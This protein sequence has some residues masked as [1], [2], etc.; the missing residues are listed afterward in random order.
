MQPLKTIIS[1]LAAIGLVM[2][3][4]ACIHREPAPFSL[5]PGLFDQEQPHTLGLV[6]PEGAETYTIYQ[7]NEEDNAYNHGV[8]LIA[9]KGRLYAQ[10]QSSHRDEDAPDTQVLYSSSSNLKDWSKPETLAPARPGAV[11]TNGGWW[12]DS[13]TLVAYITTWPDRADAP[14]GGYTQYIT[15]RDGV[16]WSKPK[17]MLNEKGLPVD[18]V[19]EQDPHALPDGRIISAFHE[20]PGL[21]VSPYY[22]DDPLAVS[23][24][25]KGAMPNLPHEGAVSRELEPSWFCRDDGA[26]VMVFRDQASSYK[27]LASVSRDRGESWTSP[28]LVDFPD[29]RSKQSAGNLPDG[30]AFR[31]NNPVSSKRR[32]PLVVT[33]SDDG[34]VFNR[35]YL[36]RGG[37]DLQDLRFEGKYKREGYSY[38]KSLVSGDYLYVAYATNKE[39]VELTRVPVE[40]L[41][42]DAAH[43]ETAGQIND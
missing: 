43:V 37:D 40:A 11:T 4:S 9:F 39:D 18:G 35:A 19:F 32:Y 2:G 17:R 38:P 31:V 8:V 20:Q 13:E 1:L 36:L 24:W 27:T 28:M 25:T 5:K 34:R 6:R 41:T 26:V 23:G 33:L 7:S 14:R 12:T 15:S 10:W 30:T 29:S 42:R 21:V 3:G 22:T 16:S